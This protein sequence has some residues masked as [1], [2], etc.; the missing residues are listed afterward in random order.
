[1]ALLMS[2]DVWH[3]EVETFIK[4][5]EDL[6]KINKANLSIEIDDSFMIG[7]LGGNEYCNK[8]FNTICTSAWRSAEPGILFT[9]K[10]RNYNI[11]EY[12][13]N[14]QIETTNPCGICLP[15]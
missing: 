1:M 11:M 15:Q 8:I 7:V 10:L 5:K 13:A 12:V 9:E 14:Y 2:I 6:N 3:P 4:I